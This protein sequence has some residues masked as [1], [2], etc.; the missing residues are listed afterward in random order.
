MSKKKQQG[1][2]CRVCRRHRAN[3]K[4]S[5][6]GHRQHVCKDCNRDLQA[7]K[8]EKKRVTKQA[9]EVGLP[10][11]KRYPMTRYQAASYLGITPDAF[12]Y[13]RKKLELEPC[14]TYEGKQGTGF[15]FD[16]DTIIAVYQHSR[17]DDQ[18][19]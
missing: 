5:G 17:E 6:K 10:K 12:D 15:L 16:M 2:Y 4:F 3:E 13:R 8:R 14:G 11:P 19:D 9:A 7:Q 1:H 18:D